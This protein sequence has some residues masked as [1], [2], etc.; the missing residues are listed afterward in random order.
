MFRLKEAA[1]SHLDRV[2]TDV[3][4]GEYVSPRSSAVT[5]GTVAAEWLDGKGARKPKTVAGYESLLD[6]L[7]LP[8]WRDT[9][10]KTSPTP[11]SSA[12]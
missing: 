10:S 7:V 8:R 6:N 1:Q 12:G 4:T 11:M 3:V 5:F 9:N 2:T